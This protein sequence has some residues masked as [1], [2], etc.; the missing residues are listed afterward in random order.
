MNDAELR[1]T[2]NH[3]QELVVSETGARLGMDA[4]SVLARILRNVSNNNLQGAEGF[5]TR[6]ITILL[7]DLR[8]FTAVSES[9][10]AGTVL[11]VL[12]RCLITMSEV[13]LK[14]HGMID[15]FMGDSI[16]VLFGGTV[17]AEDDVLRA[18]HCA[19]D[20]QIAMEELNAYYEQL[21]LPEL[22][23]GIGINTGPVMV[24]TLGSDLY[25]SHTVIGD[26]VNLASRI[27]AFS[28][29]GQVLISQHTFERCAGFVETGEPVE[30]HVKGK[31]NAVTLREVLGIPSL[32]KSIPR[33]EIRRS[34][35]VAVT[36][37][38]SYQVV[39]DKVTQPQVY[40][41]TILDI[42]SHGILVAVGHQLET[43]SEVTFDLDLALIGCRAGDIYARTVKTA[44]TATGFLSGLEFTSLSG[45]DSRNVQQFV[46]L[47]VQGSEA[48]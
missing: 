36:M 6:D 38:F 4:E 14:H 7:A 26:E 40:G 29:R 41:G 45:Q 16:M 11:K 24:G 28:L 1:A 46:Q 35:R 37:P 42:G 39:R 13:V 10:P 44:R 19:V 20:L 3:I 23:L 8:G 31:A 48:K 25:A 47:L 18:L 33:K 22:F 43:L 12:N 21:G 5:Q 17:T 9:Y 27:E 15:K 34:P 2:V 30:V 32:G